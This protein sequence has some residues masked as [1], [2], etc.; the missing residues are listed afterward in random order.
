MQLL[1]V[2]VVVVALPA[3]IVLRAAEVGLGVDLRQL[4]H[5]GQGAPEEQ[6][7][8][9]AAH[10]VEAVLVPDRRLGGG[11]G[12]AAHVARGVAHVT[13][14]GRPDGVGQGSSWARPRTPTGPRRPPWAGRARRV[15]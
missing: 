12:T 11:D 1:V 2:E 8:L 9:P 6:P 15:R 3:R 10:D 4:V 14:P 7:T 13:R 5:G